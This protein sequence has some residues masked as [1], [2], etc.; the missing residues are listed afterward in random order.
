M[1]NKFNTNQC[2]NCIKYYRG[3]R[4]NCLAF[5]DNKHPLKD[6]EDNCIAYVPI[7]F[8]FKTNKKNPA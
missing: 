2:K 8:V 4:G 1:S 3:V 5:L 6:K 7:R